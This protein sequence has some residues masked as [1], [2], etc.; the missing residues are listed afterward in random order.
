M[1]GE[2]D[3]AYREKRQTKREVFLVRN[4]WVWLRLPFFGHA[5]EMGDSLQ[6][7]QQSCLEGAL[8]S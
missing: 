6:Y 5:F 2:W 8:G 4:S 7:E 3:T 1:V